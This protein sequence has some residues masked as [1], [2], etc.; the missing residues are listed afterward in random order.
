MKKPFAGWET[1]CSLEKWVTC[2]WISAMHCDQQHISEI[3]FL[4][5]GKHLIFQQFPVHS[6][7]F[8]RFLCL[9]EE[10]ACRGYLTCSLLLMTI[11]TCFLLLFTPWVWYLYTKKVLGFGIWKCWELWLS[12]VISSS[13]SSKEGRLLIHIKTAGLRS[14]YGEGVAFLLLIA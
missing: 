7:S 10:D 2:A 9:L 1:H 11:F 6:L 12:E 14:I 13:E 4:V 8:P 3:C 5:C